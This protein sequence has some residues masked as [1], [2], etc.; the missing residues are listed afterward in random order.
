MRH[1]IGFNQWLAAKLKAEF[2]EMSVIYA[3][4]S[5][6]ARHAC[7]DYLAD[8]LR[9]HFGDSA[10]D[11][12]TDLNNTKDL[13][14]VAHA[15]YPVYSGDQVYYVSRVD[16]DLARVFPS[17]DFTENY[18]S[19]AIHEAAHIVGQ[20]CYNH[21]GSLKEENM[22]DLFTAC[23]M[24]WMGKDDY[25][26]T[27]TK[28]R[29][30]NVVVDAPLPSIVRHYGFPTIVKKAASLFNEMRQQR[31]S[32]LSFRALYNKVSDFLDRH[33]AELESWFGFSDGMFSAYYETGDF[34]E[35]LSMAK[36]AGHP[37]ADIISAVMGIKPDM[38]FQSQFEPNPFISRE[39]AHRFTRDNG[40]SEK[41]SKFPKPNRRLADI[42]QES[43]FPPDFYV[44]LNRDLIRAP[45]GVNPRGPQII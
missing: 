38:S 22:A 16:L 40:L 34:A 26:E 3:S 31:G 2:P 42:L 12:I 39:A 15:S 36:K 44:L 32:D 23:V 28:A 30:R 11:M 9:G 21:L 1:L 35:I 4:S 14:S 20:H 24:V 29:I 8:Y 5:W 37:Q 41:D 17:K 25:I 13:S 7:H 33:E 18:K 27:L 6:N 19:T 43:P 10:E 45:M